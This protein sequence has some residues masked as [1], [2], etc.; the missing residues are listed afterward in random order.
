MLGMGLRSLRCK[1]RLV[2]AKAKLASDS[3]F[4]LLNPTTA[5]PNWWL[6]RAS[7]ANHVHQIV[8]HGAGLGGGRYGGEVPLLLIR[9]RYG[10][11]GP[12]LTKLLVQF[13]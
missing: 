4:K 5:S 7:L 2:D 12:L 13:L 9:A 11:H 10:N 1:L 6:S 8:G 3:F